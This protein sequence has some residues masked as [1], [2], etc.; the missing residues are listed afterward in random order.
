M[1]SQ[2]DRDYKKVLEERVKVLETETIE[3]QAELDKQQK[4]REQASEKA[5]TDLENENKRLEAELKMQQIEHD[6][7]TL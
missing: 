6:D 7:I 1:K 4:E 3:L 2:G 5:F